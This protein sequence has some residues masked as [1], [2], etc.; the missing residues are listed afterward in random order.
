MRAARLLSLAVLSV[1]VHTYVHAYNSFKEGIWCINMLCQYLYIPDAI[2]TLV[3]LHYSQVVSILHKKIYYPG[4][5]IL[6]HAKSICC[7]SGPTY[8]VFLQSKKKIIL[9]HD[10]L[11][12]LLPTLLLSLVRPS[13]NSLIWH[14]FTR[15]V[16]NALGEGSSHDHRAYLN[17]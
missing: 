9:I 16:Q 2:W 5:E 3:R 4:P 12:P 1:D 6:G 15:R 14:G 13:N 7:C 11:F 10:S 8:P 17:G